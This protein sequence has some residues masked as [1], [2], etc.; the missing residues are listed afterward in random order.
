MKKIGNVRDSI[1]YDFLQ[2]G[3]FAELKNTEINE[4]ATTISK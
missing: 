1:T 3:H 2:D 4:R